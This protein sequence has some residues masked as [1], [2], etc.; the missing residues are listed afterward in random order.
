MSNQAT[1]N[2]V[3][4]QPCQHVDCQGC[5]ANRCLLNRTALFG[6]CDLTGWFLMY[7]DIPVLHFEKGLDQVS[8]INAEFLPYGLRPSPNGVGVYNWIANRAT[9]LTRKNANFLYMILGKPRTA[10]GQQQLIHEFGGVS[11]NDCFW[12][13][14]ANEVT[15]WGDISP[16]SGVI[17]WSSND[18]AFG[19]GILTGDIS[20]A[21]RPNR[22]IHHYNH[23]AK[24]TYCAIC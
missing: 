2:P 17:P 12:V 5:E 18:R 9:P 16:F 6:K 19:Y 7:R 4:E 20:D 10:S 23:K 22:L 13:K 8:V 3:E 11:I 21:L 1:M 15:T 14:T 24:N